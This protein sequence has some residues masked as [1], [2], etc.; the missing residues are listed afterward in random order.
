ML[1]ER[2]LSG[3]LDR[4]SEQLNKFLAGLFD[5]DGY[6]GL[7]RDTKVH[8]ISLGCNIS[9]S[10]SNDPDFE[11]M[12]ALQ[13]HY[14]FGKLYYFCRDKDNTAA[15]CTW[16][17]NSKDTKMLFNRISKHLLIKSKYFSLCLEIVDALK[18]HKVNYVAY[19]D[20]KEQMSCYKSKAGLI[21]WPKHLSWAYTAG[22]IAGDG[23]LRC[24][25]GKRHDLSVE[26]YNNSEDIMK[27][28]VSSFGGTYRQK[29]KNC[30]KWSRRTGRQNKSF[31]LSFFPRIRK[32][33]L[34]ETKKNVLTRLI[35]FHKPPAE[36]KRSAVEKQN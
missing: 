11:M 1:R 33:M 8:T 23:H 31:A 30:Y 14:G 12:R 35:N 13:K 36:T 28:M 17:F 25:I 15:E 20:L 18:L 16:R 21:K 29:T 3:K 4:H 7:L 5:T 6:I 26:L 32:Y 22:L 9:Q 19:K 24:R 27:C 34:L 2:L 10:S